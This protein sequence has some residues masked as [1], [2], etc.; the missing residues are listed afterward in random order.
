MPTPNDKDKP[1]MRS[2][3][4]FF[5]HVW[6]GVKTDPSKKVVRR[7][8]EVETRETKD[9]KVVLRRTVIEEVEVKRP[10]RP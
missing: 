7:E 3:G 10:E 2:L 6:Q 4:E 5:G 1:L 8:E 9:G